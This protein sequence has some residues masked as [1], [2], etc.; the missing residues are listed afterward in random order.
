MGAK[1]LETE[2]DQQILGNKATEGPPRVGK[3]LSAKQKIP[4]AT[5]SQ[6]S[7]SGFQ[8]SHIYGSCLTLNLGISHRIWQM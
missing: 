3:S 2:E 7:Q 5:E 8:N 4:V 6:N 1:N